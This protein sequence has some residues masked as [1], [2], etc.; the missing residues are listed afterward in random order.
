MERNPRGIVPNNQLLL[1]TPWLERA[2]QVYKASTGSIAYTE[3]SFFRGNSTIEVLD[4]ILPDIPHRPNILLIGL[5]LDAEPLLC[6]YEP[7]R[8][9]AHL[10]GRDV[11]YTMTLV[12]AFEAVIEDVRGRERL[13]LSYRQFNERLSGSFEAAWKKYLANTKQEGR[14]TFEREDGLKFIPYYDQEDAMVPAAHYLEL[15]IAVADVSSQFRRKLSGGEITLVHDDIAVANIGD[16]GLY[17]YVE[18]TNVLY[19]MQPEGQQLALANVSTSMAEGGRLLVNDIGGYFGRP[20]FTKFG[21]WL[22][23]EKMSQLGLGV[24]EVI[25]EKDLSRTVLFQRR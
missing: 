5:G 9:A 15:G 6:T 7:F 4:R 17:D 11:D 23:D 25:S 2:A 1:T 16:T 8:V 14:E 13:F 20:V 24:E 3:T 10:E 12:D 22:D 18:F 19:L 21:G